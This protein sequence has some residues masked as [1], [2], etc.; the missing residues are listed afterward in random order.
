M[1]YCARKRFDLKCIKI[2]LNTKFKAVL[3]ELDYSVL[4]VVSY[5]LIN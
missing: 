5:Y 1:P 2:Q 3:S 4:E